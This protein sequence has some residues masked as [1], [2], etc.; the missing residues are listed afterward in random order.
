MFYPSY[1]PICGINRPPNMHISVEVIGD[2]GE[3]FVEKR[4]SREFTNWKR[5]DKLLLD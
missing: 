3:K 1:V 2:P 4:M 5:V